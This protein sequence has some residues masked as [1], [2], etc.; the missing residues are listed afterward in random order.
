[1]NGMGSKCT[2]AQLL[3]TTAWSINTRY[4]LMCRM[5]AYFTPGG[6]SR[7]YLSRVADLRTRSTHSRL[8]PTATP[9][10]RSL[11]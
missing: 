9:W 11:L 3:V 2:T 4:W 7:C 5:Y 1:M 6:G 8:Q 10:G